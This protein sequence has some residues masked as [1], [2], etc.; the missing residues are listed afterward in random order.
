MQQ[1]ADHVHSGL[2]PTS[3]PQA[4]APSRR[5]ARPGHRAGGGSGAGGLGRGGGGGVRRGAAGARE[6][7]GAAARGEWGGEVV[8]WAHTVPKPG[9]GSGPKK[10]PAIGW[11]PSLLGWR[12]R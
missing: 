9:T 3:S 4:A 10:T 11:R 6:G 5:R 2:Q 1:K 12:Q 7:G 8:F